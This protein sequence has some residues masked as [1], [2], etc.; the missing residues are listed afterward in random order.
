MNDPAGN[1]RSLSRDRLMMI[2][3]ESHKVLFNIFVLNSESTEE[4]TI[5]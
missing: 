4:E 1:E 5:I 2:L 3:S